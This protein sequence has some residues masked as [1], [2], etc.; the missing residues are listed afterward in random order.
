M[1]EVDYVIPDLTIKKETTLDFYELYK[2]IKDWFERNKYD[3]IEKE[4]VSNEELKGTS[5]SVKWKPYKKLDDYCKAYI[6]VKIKVNDMVTVVKNKKKLNKGIFT[7]KFESYLEKDYEEK[8]EDKPFYKFI[9]TFYDK[10]VIG[11]KFDKY[12]KHLK[13]ETYEIFN[14]TKS[15]L[16]LQKF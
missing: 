7:V 12:S 14:E 1:S 9:R 13:D 6:E 2:F 15:F 4:F 8:W 10:L 3:F 11:D 5:I 16:D